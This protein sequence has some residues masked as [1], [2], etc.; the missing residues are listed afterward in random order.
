MPG[1]KEVYEKKTTCSI[2][3]PVNLQ[4]CGYDLGREEKHLSANPRHQIYISEWKSM[5]QQG[6]TKAS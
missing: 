2:P 5:K 6:T 3:P 4:A 1:N